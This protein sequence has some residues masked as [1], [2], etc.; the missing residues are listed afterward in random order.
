M[1]KTEETENN[2][3]LFVSEENH[4]F[5]DSHTVLNTGTVQDSLSPTTA[6]S[7]SASVTFLSPATARFGRSLRPGMASIPELG[8]NTADETT[9][10]H[11]RVNENL[12]A[13]PHQVL[14]HVDNMRSIL[15]MSRSV[16]GDA[17][18]EGSSVSNIW[19]DEVSDRRRMVGFVLGSA[20]PSGR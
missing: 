11:R 4:R 19:E 1:I 9:L 6:V 3:T 8:T 2:T 12:E 17:L 14:R 7:E 18:A 16:D 5:F 13:L 15:G 10:A 20:E